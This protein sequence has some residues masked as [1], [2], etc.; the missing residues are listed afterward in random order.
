M[1]GA[2]LN[3]LFERLLSRVDRD[4][5]ASALEP[6]P[7]AL[8]VT[9]PAADEGGTTR[10]ERGLAVP[11]DQLDRVLSAKVLHGWLQNR[12]QVLVPLTLRLGLLA[13]NDV[14]L[15]MRFVAAALL[16]A[17]AGIEPGRRNV[18]V[19][20]R[21]I[22]ADPEALAVV[23][24]AFQDP[25]ALSGVVES[26]RER[27]LEAYAYAALVVGADLRVPAQRLFVDFLAARLGLPPEAV[28]S[29]NRRYGR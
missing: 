16:S 7:P 28:R 5:Q 1:R 19:W 23:D 4:G 24:T 9:L 21:G 22:G 2:M 27:H 18:T 15:L 25:P 10:R 20:L 29:I 8:A 11:R 3:G 13:R 6:P 12:H 26:V 17:S 14:D